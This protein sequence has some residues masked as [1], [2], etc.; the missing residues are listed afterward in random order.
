MEKYVETL[1]RDQQKGV[2]LY[3][4]GVWSEKK[5][6]SYGNEEKSTVQAFSILKS[7]NTHEVMV[8]RLDDVL[9]GERI[10]FIKM[11]VE[12]SELEALKGAEN[13]IKNQ[14][15]KMAI[16]LYHKIEDFWQIPMYIKA[17]VPEYRF[18]IRHHCPAN[19]NDT[20]LY[21]EFFEQHEA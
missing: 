15:P 16:C 14:H 4:E 8:E 5:A 18:G 20:V 1:D 19:F 6:L 2:H 3:H 13:I 11:D 17:I 7:D 12:G 21:A 10:T 9:S